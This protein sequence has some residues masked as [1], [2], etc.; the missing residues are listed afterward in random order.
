VLPYQTIIPIIGIPGFGTAAAERVC[1][2]MKIQSQVGGWLG[3]RGFEWLNW[4]VAVGEVRCGS[5]WTCRSSRR[6]ARGWGL[7][8][9]RHLPKHKGKC[10]Q[11][12]G[13][14][15]L[16]QHSWALWSPFLF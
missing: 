8:A 12:T 13:T 5:A 1:L 14:N 3:V 7:T 15:S 10:L 16:A 9:C 6:W 4:E 2:D 11:A